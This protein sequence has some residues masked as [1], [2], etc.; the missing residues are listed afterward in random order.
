MCKNF[1]LLAHRGPYSHSVSGQLTTDSRP[2]G[3]RPA[4]HSQPTLAP[5]GAHLRPTRNRHATHSCLISRP[6]CDPLAT[7]N[8]LV[9]DSQSYMDRLSTCSTPNL[10]ALRACLTRGLP[11]WGPKHSLW[12]MW[13][14]PGVFDGGRVG[15]LRI[16]W[17]VEQHWV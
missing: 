10:I 15:P 9:T 1:V 8:P 14:P 2:T 4:T 7:R 17:Q 13:N 11:P 6:T 3:K 16:P 12:Y 5:F